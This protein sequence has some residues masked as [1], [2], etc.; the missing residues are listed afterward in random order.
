[1]QRGMIGHGSRARRVRRAFLPHNMAAPVAHRTE[2][3]LLQNSADFPAGEDAQ[4]T[5]P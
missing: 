1:M 5:Q 4:P 3:L 2:A